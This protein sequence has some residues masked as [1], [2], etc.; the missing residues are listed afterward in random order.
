M[1]LKKWLFTSAFALAYCFLSCKSESDK[2]ESIQLI[3]SNKQVQI[4][5]SVKVTLSNGNNVSAL[6]ISPNAGL[7]RNGYYIAP[8]TLASSIFIIELKTTI[9]NKTYSE[10]CTIIRGEKIDSTI[11]FSKTILPIL[12]S[13]CNFNGCH[14]NGSRAGRVE[15]SQHDSVVKH[16]VAYQPTQSSLYLSL[17][18]TDPLR[19]MPPAGPLNN[20]RI[21]L[22][23]NWIE[24]GA[25]NN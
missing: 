23:S 2:E 21:Q 16:L 6:S 1:R 17:I 4:N 22:I 24:Q 12:V 9:N 15:L 18:K 25:V 10:N 3:L 20:N 11:S 14:G 7:F 13:N 8:K 5:D 19:R